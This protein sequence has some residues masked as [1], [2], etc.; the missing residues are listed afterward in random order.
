MSQTQ[1]PDHE[2][3]EPQTKEELTSMKPTKILFYLLIL[4]G[5]ISS[6]AMAAHG[7]ALAVRGGT[8]GYGADFDF[9][10]TP[11]INMRL[12]Y[13]TFNLSRT[14]NDTDVTYDGTLK[15]GAASAIVDWHV[16]NGGFRLSLGAVQKGP[17]VDAVGI[18][19]GGTTYTIGNTSYTASQIGKLTGTIKMGNST[20]PYVGIGWGNTVDTEDRVTFLLDLGAIKTGAAT[21]SVVAT[22]GPTLL[23]V[24][25]DALQA[26]LVPDINKE[27]TDLEDQAKKYE[28]YPVISLGVAVRF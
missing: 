6:Q 14:I 3:D 21:A 20:S 18:P 27:V 7:F 28:W 12:G 25:C 15:I 10:L 4:C 1:L 8:F 13:N 22:C 26:S 11:S 24:A 5:F 19:S 2:F 16:F 9:G 17:T 23:P